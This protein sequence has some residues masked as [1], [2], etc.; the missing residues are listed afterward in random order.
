MLG[1]SLLVARLVFFVT[2][3]HLAIA[4]NDLF[5]YSYGPQSHRED[6]SSPR[7]SPS[8]HRVPPP[9]E[10]DNHG[11]PRRHDSLRLVAVPP[12][13]HGGALPHRG[14]QRGR[15]LPRPPSPPRSASPDLQ[16][17]RPRGASGLSFALLRQLLATEHERART[18]GRARGDFAHFS[19]A[20]FPDLSSRGSSPIRPASRAGGT[21][22]RALS[23]A[24]NVGRSKPNTPR[25]TPGQ[26]PRSRKQS[27]PGKENV[28]VEPPPGRAKGPGE[29]GRT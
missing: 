9:R 12:A 19:R 2:I 13:A 26:T 24:T 23:E 18:A 17:S 25:D 22:S 15:S 27:A 29:G 1:M 28:P 10:G 4:T 11:G 20:D 8:R 3:L 5:S 14:T 16:R 21:H 7:F 6:A